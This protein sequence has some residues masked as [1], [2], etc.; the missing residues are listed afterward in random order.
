MK[1]PL[2]VLDY[3]NWWKKELN[4]I[5]PYTIPSVKEDIIYK[6]EMQLEDSANRMFNT[7]ANAQ[8]IITHLHHLIDE[9]K[10]EHVFPFTW[11][12]KIYRSP[13]KKGEKNFEF[14]PAQ[15]AII[16][17]VHMDTAL[18]RT[19]N[20]EPCVIYNHVPRLETS[21]FVI[22]KCAKDTNTP[23]YLAEVV[24]RND[25]NSFTIQWWAPS[26][27]SQ[28]KG[29]NYHSMA[30]EAQTVKLRITNRQ[31]GAPQW[32]LKPQLDNIKFNTVYFGFSK[33]TRDRRLPAEVLRKLRALSLI[34]RHIKIKR[35]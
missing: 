25:D 18:K 27:I 7:R 20:L 19:F 30:F 33:L 17:Q 28:K 16:E 10:K 13:P 5:K 2:Q 29:G 15:L 8:D 23:F 35:M 6:M 34:S 1:N 32:R 24:S 3:E 14:S 9:Q 22:V 21:N 31:R 26:A 11:N 12:L 4:H